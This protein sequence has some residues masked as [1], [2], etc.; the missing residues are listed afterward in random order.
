L[1]GTWEGLWQST[2]LIS[3]SRIG[4]F[5]GDFVQ[6]GEGVKGSAKMTGS[7]F[8]APNVDVRGTFDGANFKAETFVGKNRTATITGKLVEAGKIEGRYSA[9]LD[10]GTIVLAK[11]KDYGR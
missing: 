4:Y 3:F 2:S 8:T 5:K 1:S 11:V 6:E 7:I 9:T 10:A